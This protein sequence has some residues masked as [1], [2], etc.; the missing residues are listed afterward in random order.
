MHF[1]LLESYQNMQTRNLLEM[2]LRPIAKPP[3]TLPHSCSSFFLQLLPGNILFSF[4][5]TPSP[6]SPFL[7]LP[8]LPSFPLPIIAWICVISSSFLSFLS[9]GLFCLI[10]SLFFVFPRFG[11]HSK[12]GPFPEKN[13]STAE[14]QLK[15]QKDKQTDSQTDRQ[16]DRQTDKN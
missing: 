8:P 14:K 6:L 9:F 13:H 7:P 11:F 10:L 1:V 16:T 2:F 3:T 5:P 12:T 4:S 15:R